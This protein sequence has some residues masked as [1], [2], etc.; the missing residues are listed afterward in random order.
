L[1][2]SR[3]RTLRDSYSF[4]SRLAFDTFWISMFNCLC[5]C[6]SYD[7][8]ENTRFWHKKKTIRSYMTIEIFGFD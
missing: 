1:I 6:L 2:S 8:E 3:N 7:Y 5:N 4:N